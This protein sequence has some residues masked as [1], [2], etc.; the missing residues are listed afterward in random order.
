MDHI[1]EVNHVQKTFGKEQAL[2]DLTFGVKKGDIFGFL[3]PSGAGKT[4]TIEILTGQQVPT[5]G[6]ARVFGVPSKDMHHPHYLKR[7]GVMSD[8]SGLYERLSIRDNL[9]LFCELYDQP[10][11]QVEEVLEIVNLTAEKNKRV[12]KLSKGMKQRTMLA[13]ALLHQPDLLFLDEPTGALDPANAQHIHHGLRTLNQRGTTIFLTTHDMNEAETLCSTVA[14]LDKGSIQL[15][16]CP[17]K[18]RKQFGDGH[19][20]V[21]LTDGREIMLPNEPASAEEIYQWMKNSEVE[22]I[23]MNTPT[24]GDIFVEVTGRNLV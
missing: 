20:M 12:S 18:L 23:E 13:R 8:S 14:F 2:R 11:T 16:D 1:I 5:S 9:L 3:G 21:G 19:L 22:T 24:L 7:I 15:L 6:E 4:T 17:K 10:S